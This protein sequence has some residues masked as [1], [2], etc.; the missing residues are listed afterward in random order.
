MF[1]P[2]LTHEVA[3]VGWGVEKGVEFWV[4]RNSWG[5]YWGESGFFRIRMHK[6]NLGIEK[7]CSWG[8]VDSQPHW[9]DISS[10]N[11][12]IIVSDI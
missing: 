9:V 5:T 2:I 12:E 10:E 1:S 11:K 8:S 3:I 4:G 6:H 7:D